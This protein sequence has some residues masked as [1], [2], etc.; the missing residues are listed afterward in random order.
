MSTVER[1][2]SPLLVENFCSVHDQ[3]MMIDSRSLELE[4]IMYEKQ[5]LSSEPPESAVDVL[6]C[7]VFN[8]TDESSRKLL[9]GLVRR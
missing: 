3:S 1:S 7:D 6:Q 5:H 9:S 8:D 4:G 2:P